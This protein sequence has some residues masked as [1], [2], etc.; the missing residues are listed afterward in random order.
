MEGSRG[1]A[2]MRKEGFGGGCAVA[3][4]M[5]NMDSEDVFLLN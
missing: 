4:I 3:K 1:A 5:N 2:E